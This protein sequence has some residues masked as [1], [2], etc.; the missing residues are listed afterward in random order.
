MYVQAATSKLASRT[1]ELIGKR[2]RS[3]LTI[4]RDRDQLAATNNDYYFSVF[5]RKEQNTK[6][7][8]AT[9]SFSNMNVPGN[10]FVFSSLK[11][12]FNK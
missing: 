12:L 11:G 9:R 7:Q 5:F 2:F 8:P 10:P 4:G 3:K 1:K 6:K